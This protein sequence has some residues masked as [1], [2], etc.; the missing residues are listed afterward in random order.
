MASVTSCTQCGLKKNISQ[1]YLDS[2]CLAMS[3]ECRGMQ[4]HSM[5]K[6][7]YDINGILNHWFTEY[8]YLKYDTV[9]TPRMNVT[10][11]QLKEGTLRRIAEGKFRIEKADSFGKTFNCP[12]VMNETE[13]FFLNNELVKISVTKGYPDYNAIPANYWIVMRQVDLLCQKNKIVNRKAY[14][15]SGDRIQLE[16]SEIEQEMDYLE[17]DENALIQKAQSLYNDKR[18]EIEK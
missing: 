14:W 6:E 5:D 17:I 13:Y 7:V 10:E 3:D 1:N 15:Y 2:L 12:M 4:V 18:N 9:G 8:L 16:D 11:K